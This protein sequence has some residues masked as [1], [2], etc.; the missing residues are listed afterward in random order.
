MLL[1]VCPHNV[2]VDISTI[3]SFK[4]MKQ[5]TTDFAVVVEALR[6]STKLLQLDDKEEKV[7]RKIPLPTAEE[8]E[9]QKLR[10][11]RYVC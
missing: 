1:L 8:L 10:T 4:R 2:G 9:A 3:A 5:L 7:K 6:H 11:I